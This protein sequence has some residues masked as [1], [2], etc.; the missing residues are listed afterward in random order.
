VS[1]ANKAGRRDDVGVAEGLTAWGARYFSSPQWK[2]VDLVRPSSGWANETV[3]ITVEGH[4]QRETA[5]RFVVRM[6]ALIPVF[7][8][9]DL[10]AQAMVLKSV[11]GEGVP[12][13]S[14]IAVEGDEDW[15]GA[16]F[17]V[18]SYEE[19]RPGPEVPTL[20]GWLIDAPV[21]SQRGLHESFV[22]TIARIHG[23]DWRLAGLGSALRGGTE[24]S[25]VDEV[26]WW[27]SYV[28][29]ATDAS[30]PSLLADALDW[31]TAT[32]PSVSSPL[33]LCWGDA[34]I[35]NVLF[36]EASE[37]RAVLDWELA[38]I[39]VGEMDVGWV[40]ALDGL[41]ERFTGRRVPGFMRRDEVIACY[42]RAA[43][44]ELHDVQWHELFALT[45]SVAVA[46]RLSIVA[47]LGGIEYPGGGGNE[48]PVLRELTR[49]IDG[50]AGE[51]PP[52]G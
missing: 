19:G 47:N 4:P 16:P 33:S 26:R 15:V 3:M 31:C 13:P 36:G 48:D 24:G 39:G 41:I 46:E 45:R 11:K 29:W 7:P 37:I 18:M 43:G 14:P 22:Q 9:Y 30:P 27:R 44:R 49:K 50:Y 28:E 5:E 34:R 6:P 12:A 40:V 51:A 25:L 8:A 20:D 2:V 42:E 32:A 35:G 38:S 52:S 17:L 23:V 10:E 21:D 1:Q